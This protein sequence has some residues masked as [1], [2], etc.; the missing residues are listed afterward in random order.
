MA[1]AIK[2]EQLQHD[3]ASL[4]DRFATLM[5]ESSSKYSGEQ[6]AELKHQTHVDYESRLSAMRT[7]MNSTLGAA[8]ADTSRLKQELLVAKAGAFT[9][10]IEV[11][12][13]SAQA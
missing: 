11:D 1:L 8:Q 6:V 5:R 2:N 9:T 12:P 3:L 13:G 10:A 7:E 4:N